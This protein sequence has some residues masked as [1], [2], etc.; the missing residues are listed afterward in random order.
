MLLFCKLSLPILLRCTFEK[1]SIR[2]Y[3]VSF[4]LTVLI[5]VNLQTFNIDV[6]GS[7]QRTVFSKY[8]AL[9]QS[10]IFLK[11]FETIFEIF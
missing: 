7:L 6:K 1:L 9:F 3:S 10:K 4:W 2:F 11:Y 5:S 8:T